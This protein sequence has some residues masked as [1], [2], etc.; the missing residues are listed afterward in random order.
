MKIETRYGADKSAEQ[1]G[2]VI[3]EVFGQ[4]LLE[5]VIESLH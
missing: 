3:M 4:T 5:S 2:E 1:T